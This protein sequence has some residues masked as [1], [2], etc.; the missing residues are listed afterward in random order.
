MF[1]LHSTLG[2]LFV[3]TAFQAKQNLTA[4]FQKE[5]FDTTIDQF[6]VIGA[7]VRADGISQKEICRICCKN[8]SNLT[9]ILKGMEAKGLV[10][11]KKGED[12]RS[13]NV[14]LTNKGRTLFT[15]LAPISE[16]YMYQVLDHLSDVERDMLAKLVLRIREKL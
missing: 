16:K 6:A 9:R 13:R 10:V 4:L 15:S 2:F 5:G 11:R 8:E 7:L 14:Y 1:D 12:A 3:N